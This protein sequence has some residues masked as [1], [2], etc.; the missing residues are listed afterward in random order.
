LDEEIR[1]RLHAK[2]TDVFV[3]ATRKFQPEYVLLWVVDEQ[4]QEIEH[5]F[6]EMQEALAMVDPTLDPGNEKILTNEK[7]AQ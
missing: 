7:G 5:E 6:I 1:N 2:A 4:G 3:S